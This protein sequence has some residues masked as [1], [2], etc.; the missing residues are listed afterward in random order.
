MKVLPF[1]IDVQD[2]SALEDLV[3]TTIKHFGKIDILIN[4]AGALWWKIC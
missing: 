4:N 3:N 2:T 1:Q